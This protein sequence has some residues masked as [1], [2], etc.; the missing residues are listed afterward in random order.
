MSAFDEE[1]FDID[2]AIEQS[3]F[4]EGMDSFPPPQSVG[5]PALQQQMP[6]W[7]A[8]VDNDAP[9]GNFVAPSVPPLLSGIVSASTSLSSNSFSPL[10]PVASGD[11]TQ[12]ISAAVD[13]S[14]HHTRSQ[15]S[16]VPTHRR[17]LTGKRGN[18]QTTKD[19]EAA[20]VL[21]TRPQWWLQMFGQ[22]RCC[23]LL[24]PTDSGSKAILFTSKRT[25]HCSYSDFGELHEQSPIELGDTQ[26]S[27]F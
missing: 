10:L 11:P 19:M 24:P 1:E 22:K 20:A 5:Q 26:E 8:G 23:P 16:I 18:A 7:M 21:R 14:D 13:S 4:D 6:S 25:G 2:M 17:R 9:A 27:L 3:L 12:Q 15:A